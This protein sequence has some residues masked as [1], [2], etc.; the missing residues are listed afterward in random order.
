MIKILF[1]FDH[2]FKFQIVVKSQ[3]HFNTS[4]REAFIHGDGPMNDGGG[5]GRL[6]IGSLWY[7]VSVS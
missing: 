7:A 6:I 4:W 1:E 3:I 5:G 2:F